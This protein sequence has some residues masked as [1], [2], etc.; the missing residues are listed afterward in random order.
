MT[1]ETQVPTRWIDQ[2]AWKVIKLARTPNR[3]LAGQIEVELKKNF[4]DKTSWQK[5]LKD[6]RN[7]DINL[8]EEK[9]RA[10]DLLPENL[11]QYCIEDDKITEIQ[12]P[13]NQYPEK[14]KS[15]NFDKLETIE[16]KLVGIRGQYLIFEDN[17]VFNIRRHNGYLV[18]LEAYGLSLI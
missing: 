14:V 9:N 1:R 8:I 18:R 4:T 2:G 13:V 16:G 17:Q 11:E 3:N 7:E 15:M 5:M 6:L 12:Y 10:W